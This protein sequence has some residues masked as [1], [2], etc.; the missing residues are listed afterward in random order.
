MNFAALVV[1][2][3]LLIFWIMAPRKKDPYAGATRGD[4]IW[5]GHTYGDAKWGKEHGWKG[6][7]GWKG[8][9]KPTAIVTGVTEPQDA[10]TV[11]NDIA[12]G[13]TPTVATTST[14]AT[15]PG[16][17]EPGDKSKSEYA[18]RVP[19]GSNWV[20]P[21]GF[22]DTGCSWE[23]GNDMVQYSCRKDAPQKQSG[24]AKAADATVGGV[25]TGIK[26]TGNFFGKL[27]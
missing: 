2:M 21:D 26:E 10:S 25:K 3:G 14:A 9:K 22:Q 16:K 6:Y 5:Y 7:K 13:A 27:F 18:Q 4:N 24:G 11:Q 8:W 15:T 12:A 19:S 23:H 20:C 17:C 1:V